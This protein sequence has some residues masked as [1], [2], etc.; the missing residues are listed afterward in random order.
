M[1]KAKIAAIFAAAFLVA[2]LAAFF[3]FSSAA[4]KN[5]P[6]GKEITL[7]GEEILGVLA[8]SVVA[9]SAASFLW[10]KKHPFVET[11][12]PQM[13]RRAVALFPSFNQF[14][15]S[16]LQ[17]RLNIETFAVASELADELERQGYVRKLPDSR[18]D[19][20]RECEATRIAPRVFSM[21]SLDAMD[22]HRF[23]YWCADVLRKNGFNDVEVTRGSGD[24]GVDV[25][26][27]KDGVKY[28]I[29]CKC[30]T[31]DLGNK[32]VQEVNTGKTIYRC[33]VGV[34]MTNRYFTQG[35][36]DAAEA[37]G[38]LLWDRDVVQ[39]MAKLANMA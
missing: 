21:N 27:E 14:S 32:P 22:G 31:S 16:Y 3:V 1:R 34:V 13:I 11:L 25:L 29:Q 4:V 33:Q 26:A 2:M 18:W 20:L 7:G 15:I 8:I 12:T 17:R 30:Y 38:I 10:V 24:Q 23:E 36:K 39:K 6:G 9:G 19:I 28:A 35:A 37:T 5:D